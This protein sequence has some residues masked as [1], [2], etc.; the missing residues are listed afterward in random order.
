[1]GRFDGSNALASLD[2]WLLASGGTGLGDGP[3]G[4]G[5]LDDGLDGGSEGFG[6]GALEARS[7]A[8]SASDRMRDDAMPGFSVCIFSLPFFLLSFR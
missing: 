2:T 3:R 4:D 7:M 8:L 5:G 6:E 1:M